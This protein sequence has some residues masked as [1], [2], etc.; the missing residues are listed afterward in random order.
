MFE[1]RESCFPFFK[2]RGIG[3]FWDSILA[4]GLW[5]SERVEGITISSMLLRR[6]WSMLAH[7]HGQTWNAVEI[8]GSLG[9]SGHTM[10]H[11]LDILCETFMGFDFFGNPLGPR[12]GQECL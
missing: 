11:Y 9:V 4:S 12:A 6:F 1:S 5:R 8:G 7:Y 2:N 3:F 10:R